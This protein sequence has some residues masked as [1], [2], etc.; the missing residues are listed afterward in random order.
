MAAEMGVAAPSKITLEG[1]FLQ[2]NGL[3]VTELSSGGFVK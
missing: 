3:T 1:T 2:K